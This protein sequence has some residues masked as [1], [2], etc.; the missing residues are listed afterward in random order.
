MAKLERG[1]LNGVYGLQTFTAAELRAL[2]DQGESQIQDP[3]NQDDPRWLR[4][5]AEDVRRL[6][7]KKEKAKAHKERQ[8]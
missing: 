2:A 3:Q 1:R 8:R 4:R 7:A 6:A 5:W